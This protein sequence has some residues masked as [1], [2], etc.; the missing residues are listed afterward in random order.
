MDDLFKLAADMAR[1]VASII[2]C[3]VCGSDVFKH[4][5]Q[6]LACGHDMEVEDE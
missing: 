2:T 3:P 1:I 6:C 5:D 4:D